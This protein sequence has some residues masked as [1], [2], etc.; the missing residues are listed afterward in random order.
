LLALDPNH[1]LSHHPN[2]WARVFLLLLS[3]LGPCVEAETRRDEEDEQEQEE[4]QL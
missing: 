1:L 4:R 3:L 2:L